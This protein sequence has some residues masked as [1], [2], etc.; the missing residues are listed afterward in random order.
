MYCATQFKV[1]QFAALDVEQPGSKLVP[2]Q[3]ILASLSWGQVQVMAWVL[4]VVANMEKGS[5]CCIGLCSSS[6][7]LSPGGLYRCESL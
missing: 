1:G 3:D 5:L 7:V 2:L 6:F 4:E